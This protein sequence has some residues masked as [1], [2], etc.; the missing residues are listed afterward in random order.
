MENTCKMLIGKRGEEMIWD[1]KVNSKID[2]EGIDVTASS[3]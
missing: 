3:G 1:W 2:S